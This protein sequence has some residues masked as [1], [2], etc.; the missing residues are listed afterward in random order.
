MVPRGWLPALKLWNLPAPRRFRMHPPMIDRA[1]FPVQRKRTLRGA[2]L[3]TS[4]TGGPPLSC[5]TAF[6][7]D[8]V[9]QRPAKLWLAVAKVLHQER[10]ELAGSGKVHRID[11]RASLLRE[12]TRRARDS[13]AMWK[14]SVFYGS[15]SCRAMSPAAMPRGPQWMSSRKILSQLCCAKPPSALIALNIPI[16]REIWKYRA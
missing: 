14:E 7:G 11:D 13:V 3:L 6:G 1:E 9:D 2:L 5:R 12:V 8:G 16:Y 4:F 10:Q 15:L